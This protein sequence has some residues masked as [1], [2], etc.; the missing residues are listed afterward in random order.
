MTAITTLPWWVILPLCLIVV[1]GVALG[2]RVVLHRFL[3]DATPHALANSS[4]F[5]AGFGAL[6]AFLSAFVISTEW[7]A[8]SAAAISERSSA[9]TSTEHWRK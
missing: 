8:Q 2:A 5:M 6:F 9:V 7:A 4:T 3:G 1:F